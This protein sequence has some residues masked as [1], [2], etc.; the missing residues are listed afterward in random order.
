MRQK[1]PYILAAIIIVAGILLLLNKAFNKTVQAPVE[2]STSQN[3]N[4][5]NQQGQ[6]DQAQ[7]PE[8][9]PDQSSAALPPISINNCPN[10]VDILRTASGKFVA[11]VDIA[12]KLVTMETS[13]GKIIVELYDQDAPKTVENFVCLVAKGYYDGIKFHRVAK[14]FVVQAGDPTGTGAGGESIYGKEFEDELNPST[15]SYKTGYVKGVLAMANRGKNTNTSQFFITL[16]DVNSALQKNYTIFGKVIQGM[17]VVEKIDAVQ[18]Y[19]PQDGA[20]LED[21]LIKK[22]TLSDK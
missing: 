1:I 20:P 17:D 3:Q 11:N 13:K 14:G 6:Q 21:V 8:V 16:A 2:T 10:G 15:S 19:P 9:K 12:N 7:D 18:T 4:Q 5:Q 22:A